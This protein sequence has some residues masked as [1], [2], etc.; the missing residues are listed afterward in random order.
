MTDT[1][2][3]TRH[4][5]SLRFM[6]SKVPFVSALGLELLEWEEQQ[7]HVVVRMPCSELV[8]NGGGTPHGG[9]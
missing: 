4:G 8:D 7:D 5:K 9:R 1:E 2:L 6:F 3:R